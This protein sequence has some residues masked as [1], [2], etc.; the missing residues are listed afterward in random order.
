MTECRDLA[1]V[2]E[3]IDR[4]D[5]ELVPLIARRTRFV[6]QAARFKADKAQ[7]IDQPRIEEVIA[8]VRHL[9]VEEGMPPDMA[10][11]IW[12]AIIDASIL[13]EAEKWKE[14][15]SKG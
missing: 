2:R 6:E 7:V 12:R 10:E 13:H 15:H 14:F 3:N 4:I 9:A 11:R 1:D 5:R 8:K